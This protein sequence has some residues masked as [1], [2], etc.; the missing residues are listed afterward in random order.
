M[1]HMIVMIWEKLKI[2]KQ[3]I[4]TLIKVLNRLLCS[5]DKANV[6]A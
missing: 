1:M 5:T 3:A 2:K 6:T 4:R